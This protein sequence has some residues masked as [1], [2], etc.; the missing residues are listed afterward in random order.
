VTRFV[1]STPL[2]AA[3]DVTIDGGS[4]VASTFVRTRRLVAP[5]ARDALARRV[6]RQV[7]AYFDRALV[8]FDLP[9]AF[10]GSAFERSVWDIVMEIPFGATLSYAEV[11][12]AAG[13]PR[14]HRAVA[15]AMGRTPLALFIPA[16]RVIGADGRVKGAV[17][18][19]LRARLLAFER[20]GGLSAA[21]AE[22]RKT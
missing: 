10:E 6:A 18:S 12:M 13:R 1:V 16:Q 11:A 14:S 19:S 2:R 4:V 5:P 3:L 7:E 15:R 22:R 8:R 20:G 21:S 17:A 9:L